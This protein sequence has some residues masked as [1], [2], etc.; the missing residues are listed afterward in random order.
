[1]RVL[2]WLI[3]VGSAAA[4]AAAFKGDVTSGAAAA[5]A[6]AAAQQADAALL[7]KAAPVRTRALPHNQPASG[8]PAKPTTPAASSHPHS[9]GHMGHPPAPA[10]S[11]PSS[12]PNSARSRADMLPMPPTHLLSP[13]AFPP[14]PPPPRRPSAASSISSSLTASPNAAAL[15][16]PSTLGSAVRSPPAA[17]GSY[18]PTGAAAAASFSTGSVDLTASAAC[19]YLVS[20]WLP[21][22]HQQQQQLQNQS[23]FSRDVL[24]PVSPTSLSTPYNGLHATA[25]SSAATAAPP[26]RSPPGFE[27]GGPGSDAG[28]GANSATSSSSGSSVFIMGL[29]SQ[30]S[31]SFHTPTPFQPNKPASTGLGAFSSVLPSGGLLQPSPKQQPATATNI[32]PIFSGSSVWSP[33]AVRGSGTDTWSSAAGGFGSWGQAA[34]GSGM[35]A[36][37]TAASPWAAPGALPSVPVAPA[38]PLPVMGLPRM[39]S[40]T[41]LLGTSTGD[42]GL[43]AMH[44]AN[45]VMRVVE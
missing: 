34:A 25:S 37:G 16:S 33:T 31:P 41:D 8:P 24:L 13:G 6:A 20:T 39:P 10:F 42:G 18:W 3:Y 5:A 44:W 12:T 17:A 2:P 38:S 40:E 19:D 4:G 7:S 29:P 14:P 45:E 35:Q 9:M 28:F 11:N 27:A 15:F 43:D 23:L 21:D 1:M 32:F 30:P 26:K 22:Q 36:A